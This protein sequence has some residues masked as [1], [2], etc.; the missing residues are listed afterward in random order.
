M[1]VHADPVEIRRFASMLKAFNNDLSS[2]TRVLQGQFQNLGQTWNDPQ[3]QKFAQEFQ[4][5]IR[6]LQQFVQSSE[7]EIPLLLKMAEHLEQAQSVY[8]RGR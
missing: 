7:H 3:H 4:Q 1:A 5:L 2:N 6:I 8:G